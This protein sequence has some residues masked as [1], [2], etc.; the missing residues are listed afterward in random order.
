MDDLYWVER[1]WIAAALFGT[2]AL[3]V[4]VV[5]LALM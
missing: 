2:L 4:F 3:I 5:A 1:V